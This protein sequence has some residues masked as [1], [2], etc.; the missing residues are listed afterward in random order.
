[1]LPTTGSYDDVCPEMLYSGQGGGSA[2]DDV[3]TSV[4]PDDDVF[5]E[6]SVLLG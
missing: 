4:L 3:R 5:T 6:A 1:M 2:G